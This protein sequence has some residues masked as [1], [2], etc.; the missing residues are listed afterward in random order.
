MDTHKQTVDCAGS[1]DVVMLSMDVPGCSTRCVHRAEMANPNNKRHKEMAHCGSSTDE[2]SCSMVTGA[3]KGL[4]S[5]KKKPTALATRVCSGSTSAAAFEV[6][7]LAI[8]SSRSPS[9]AIAQDFMDLVVTP[10]L[11][12]AAE[13]GAPGPG[14]LHPVEP[15]SPSSYVMDTG[16][17]FHIPDAV[18]EAD[19]ISTRRALPAP[20]SSSEP[21][22]SSRLGLPYAAA[23]CSLGSLTGT[24]MGA[25]K[26][27]RLPLRPPDWR[28]TGTAASPASVGMG[29]VVFGTLVELAKETVGRPALATGASS[30]AAGGTRSPSVEEPGTNRSLTGGWTPVEMAATAAAAAPFF[31][32]TEDHDE[33]P[34]SSDDCLAIS[35]PLSSRIA[36]RRTGVISSSSMAA[37]GM[38][39]SVEATPAPFTCRT[40]PS[41]SQPAAVHGR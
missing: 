8:T 12:G 20:S 25:W 6:L 15:P 9:S 3:K 36:G 23:K 41:L 30:A 28:F 24:R 10:E 35:S 37:P 27:R 19:A 16:L 34:L 31:R 5:P 17:N 13:E 2:P 40:C 1:R 32:L 4:V 33:P 38:A 29:S 11:F 21:S 26:R 7:F 18:T 22:S 39:S 14:G